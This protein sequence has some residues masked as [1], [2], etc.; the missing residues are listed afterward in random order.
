MI[1]GCTIQLLVKKEIKKDP[2]NQPI[3]EER[4]IEIENVLIGQPETSDIVNELS[5][6]GKHLAYV[7]A[8]PKGDTNDWE[9]TKVKFFNHV[10]HTYGMVTQGID[11][12]IPLSWNKKIKVE[13]YE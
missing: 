10:F 3:Y 12:N 8:I 6:N 9:D 2:F 5:I 1:K 11:E 4:W 7:L 13:L